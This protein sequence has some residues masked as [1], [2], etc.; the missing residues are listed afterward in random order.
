MV[1]EFL[2]LF[3]CLG[4]SHLSRIQQEKIMHLRI[5]KAIEILE[6]GKNNNKYWER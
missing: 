3:A 6:Y 5:N 2:L 4:L 1:L